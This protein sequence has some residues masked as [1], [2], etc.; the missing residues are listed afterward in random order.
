MSK[1]LIKAMTDNKS[2]Q[3]VVTV[4]QKL[5]NGYVRVVADNFVSDVKG[6]FAVGDELVLINGQPV[7]KLPAITAVYEL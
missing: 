2:T 7:K 3:R 4:S 6:D 5:H 1:Q